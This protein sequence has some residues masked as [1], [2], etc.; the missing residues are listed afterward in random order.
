[1]SEVKISNANDLGTR[2]RARRVELHLTQVE[3]AEVARVTP[4]LVGELER[5][6][7][8]AHLEGVIRTLA[9]LG[10][11]IYLHTR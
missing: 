8:T 4:R 3:L 1:M 10:L 11:D 7:S 6:K 5:G 9:A 2:I